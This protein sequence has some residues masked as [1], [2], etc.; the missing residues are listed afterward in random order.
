MITR[1]RAARGR[2]AVAQLVAAAVVV[3]GVVW[4][5]GQ[6]AVTDRVDALEIA[7]DSREVVALGSTTVALEQ[8][9]LVCA[10]P[11]LL[12]LSGARD[13]E[14]ATSATV[15]AAPLDELGRIPA[16]N[17]DPALAIGV[18]GADRADSPP[19]QTGS[20]S[21]QLT[22]P[23]SYLATGMGAAAPGL[24]ATQE[25]R[26]A[27]EEV[28]GLGTVPCQIPAP[29]AWLLGGGSGPGRAERLVL[30]NPG[31]NSVTVDI[32]A[33]GAEGPVAPPSGQG[34]VVPGHGRVVLLGDA[35]L[36][37]E[38]TPVFAITAHG[39]DI[40]AVLVETA[41]EG[42]RPVGFDT[43]GSSAPPAAEQ[44]IAGVLQPQGEAGTVTVRIANPGDAEA[45]A[46]ISYLAEEGEIA[47]PEGVARVAAGSVTDVP[48]TELPP[49][50]TTLRVTA[51]SPIVAAVR[52]VVDDGAGVD[53][54]WAVAQPAV[55]GLA[56]GALPA[57]EDLTRSLV[58]SAWGGG[59][60]VEVVE[61]GDGAPTTSRVP[62]P[63]GGSVV[64]AAAG[65][66]IWVRP[67]SGTGAVFA[68]VVS[69]RTGED[70]PQVSSMPLT[71][72]PTSARRSEVVALP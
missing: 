16:P 71:A 23:G 40:T 56:G 9:A 28:T 29:E 25:T 30:S 1:S 34:V 32:R 54:L 70:G 58:V 59:S 22:T 48:V 41:I 50:V 69:V 47:L 21:E 45:I 62:L 36:P 42:T 10:G 11:E 37:D 57:A 27:T 35:L 39:G 49:G 66:G 6:P 8:A 44:I 2:R 17:G 51:D 7:R 63:D 72:P 53:A 38:E 60:T 31:S 18:A 61:V 43:V 64:V 3:G 5:A 55:T 67:V 46:T 52:S 68:A 4:A 20:V 33:F 19:P 65:D 24:V 12:G 26:A 15:V 14:L 13:V